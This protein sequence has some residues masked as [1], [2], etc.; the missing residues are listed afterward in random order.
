MSQYV[1]SISDTF[2]LMKFSKDFIGLNDDLY[3]CCT[4]LPKLCPF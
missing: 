2:V 3:I 1:K 4:H